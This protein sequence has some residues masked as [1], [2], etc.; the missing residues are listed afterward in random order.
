MAN[1]SL[2]NFDPD[3]PGEHYWEYWHTLPAI[4][5]Q[6]RNTLADPLY[7]TLRAALL[8]WIDA[9]RE[10]PA[11]VILHAVKAFAYESEQDILLRMVEDDP[12]LL[13]DRPDL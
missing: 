7:T 6:V 5:Q 12:S 8:T 2:D 11:T 1:D 4:Q 9:H 10:I 13:E 3:I